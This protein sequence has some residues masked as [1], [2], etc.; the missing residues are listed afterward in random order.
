MPWWQVV[1]TAAAVVAAVTVL[2]KAFLP[3]ARAVGMAEGAYALLVSISKEFQ[4][5]GGSS[6]KDVINSIDRRLESIDHRVNTQEHRLD[7]I[8]SYVHNRFHDVLNKVT[9]L[10]MATGVRELLDNARE[11][12]EKP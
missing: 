9:I 12:K 4:R 8:E 10:E 3:V 6:L 1:I 5:N 7:E 2:W 11:Q